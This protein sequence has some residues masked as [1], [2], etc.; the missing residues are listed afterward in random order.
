M[1]KWLF[2][3]AGL[4]FAGSA[5][6]QDYRAG[7]NPY[8]G[9]TLSPYLNLLR[10]GSPAVNY[11]M[12]VVPDRERQDMPL[13]SQGTFPL[14]TPSQPP[15]SEHGELLPMLP[16]TGH[17]ASFLFFGGYYSYN[18]PARSYFPLTPSRR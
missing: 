9:T 7:Y 14:D 10:G 3:L 6:A 5:S 4:W 17:T 18:T 11:Y 15:I 1:K 8:R 13:T 2:A 12:S 16:Q